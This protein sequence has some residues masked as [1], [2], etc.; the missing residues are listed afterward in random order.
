MWCLNCNRHLSRCICPDIED[1]LARLR[2]CKYLHIPSVVEKPLLERKMK[3]EQPEPE[4][5]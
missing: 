3:K 1:R 2:E 4:K 5:Q